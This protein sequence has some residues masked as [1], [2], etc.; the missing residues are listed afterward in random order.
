M[1][2]LTMLILDK[3]L[4]DS[5]VEITFFDG[6]TRMHIKELLYFKDMNIPDYL[7]LFYEQTN[8]LMIDTEYLKDDLGD[9][10][11]LLVNACDALTYTT[12][13]LNG[14]PDKRFLKFAGNDEEALYLFD[15]ENLNPD[16]NPLIL[17]NIPVYKQIIPLTN[18][19]EVFLEC[20]CLGLLGLIEAYCE[21][22]VINR[23]D[24]PNAML[25]KKERILRCL[26]ELF[27]TSKRE[28]ELL[29]LWHVSAES[30]K[31]IQKSIAKWFEELKRLLTIFR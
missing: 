28:Y 20:S 2:V 30:Q 24:I 21:E 3:Y 29:Q 23:N 8:G 22:R 13:K 25:K 26:K 31:M 6:L 14:L 18:S 16:D 11:H 1:L 7:K 27:E 9:S 5:K 19:F 17:I 15:M 4:D 10:I 12:K